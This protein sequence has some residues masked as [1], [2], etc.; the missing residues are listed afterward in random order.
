MLLETYRECL[1]DVF[2]MPA[3]VATLRE[4]QQRRIRVVTVDS[5]QPSPFAASLLFSYVANYIYDGDAPLAERRAQALSI[6][7]TQLRELLGDAELRELLDA[8]AMA[9]VERELQ[10]LEPY[11]AASRSLDGLHDLLLRIGDLS[12]DEVAARA[13]VDKPG[14]AARA[15]ADARRAVL[16]PIAGETRFIAVEDAAAIAMRSGRRCRSGCR[17]RCSSRCAIRCGPGDALRAHARA[18]SPPTMW[19]GASGLRIRRVEAAL[20]RAVVAGRLHEGEFRPGGTHRE[21]CEPGVLAQIRRRSLAKVRHEVE[22]VEPAVLGRLMTS[23]QGIVRRRRGPD[24]L[25][26]AIEQLQGAPLAASILEREI[27]PAR[28]EAYDPGDLDCCW[29]PVKWSGAAS[30]RSASATAASRST[31]PTPSAA[32]APARSTSHTTAEGEH[33]PKGDACRRDHASGDPQRRAA[34]SR[35]RRQPRPRSRRASA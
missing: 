5:M 35:R 3:L 10:Q 19:R 34:G 4:V 6:D 16:L 27:L 24:A 20:R 30:S 26:D 2:D 13:A 22:P 12:F 31:S 7:H 32:L 25:L 11:P 21:W 28:I 9:D 29:P 17:S 18:R 15:L 33:T 14:D 23:W 8:E 1:R